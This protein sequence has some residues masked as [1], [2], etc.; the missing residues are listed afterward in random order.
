[1]FVLIVSILFSLNFVSSSTLSEKFNHGVVNYFA[2]VN[3][4]NNIDCSNYEVIQNGK[5][6]IIKTDINKAKEI[7]VSGCSIAGECVEINKN[8][9]LNNII[10]KLNLKIISTEKVNNC[11]VLSGHTNLL[12]SSLKSNGKR[13]NIQIAETENTYL[14]GYPLILHSY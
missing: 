7:L 12:P 3:N 1:M 4:L 10:K 13:I 5:G 11:V 8:F 14:I 9:S 6:A 2:Y